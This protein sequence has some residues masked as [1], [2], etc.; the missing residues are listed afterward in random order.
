MI[1]KQS[2]SSKKKENFVEIRKPKPWIEKRHLELYVEN[3]CDFSEISTEYSTPS[4]KVKN[5]TPYKTKSL[6]E[7]QQSQPNCFKFSDEKVMAKTAKKRRRH[8]RALKRKLSSDYTIQ[9]T[10]VLGKKF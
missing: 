4:Q 3:F 8:K 7:D 5:S 10:L 2:F 6:L 1:K 9:T